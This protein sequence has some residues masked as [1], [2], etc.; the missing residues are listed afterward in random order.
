MIDLEKLK[1]LLQDGFLV[2]SATKTPTESFDKL[3]ELIEDLREIELAL[4]HESIK[5]QVKKES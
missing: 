1:R 4:W 2:I 3:Q 5:E